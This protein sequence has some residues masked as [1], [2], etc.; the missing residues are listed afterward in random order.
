[1]L[2]W[3]FGERKGCVVNAHRPD[4]AAG[5]LELERARVR[6]FLSINAEHLPEAVRAGGKRTY[7]VLEID[8]EEFEFS[9]GFTDLHTRTY[10]EILAGRGCRLEDARQ[11][12][13]TAHVIRG[14]EPVGSAGEYH[15][16]CAKL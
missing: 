11:A 12:I 15:P 10:A 7:R 3:V 13:E 14:A 1:M 9:E 16:F 6:W 2:S 5:V 4:A 8:G